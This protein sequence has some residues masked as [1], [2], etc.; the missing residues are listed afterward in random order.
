VSNEEIP[1][2]NYDLKD[3][4]VI[5]D[6]LEDNLYSFKHCR[7]NLLMRIEEAL[8]H[9]PFTLRIMFNP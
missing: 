3:I 7:E 4:N 5:G 2:C 1:D 9:N 8:K 6:P